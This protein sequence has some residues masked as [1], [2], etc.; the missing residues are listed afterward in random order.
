MLSYYEICIKIS[1][2]WSKKWDNESMVP[3]TFSGN[4]WISFDDT[5]S[6]KIKVEYL[7]SK[8]KS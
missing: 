5:E 4:E 6:L 2:G 3:Y 8:N 1:Q 7:K